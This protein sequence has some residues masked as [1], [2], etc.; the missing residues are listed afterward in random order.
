[1]KVLKFL[2]M[3]FLKVNKVDYLTR[4]RKMQAKRSSPNGTYKA[5]NIKQQVYVC[6]EDSEKED[7]DP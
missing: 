5:N 7:H 4:K 1:M 3:Y 6:L 2:T